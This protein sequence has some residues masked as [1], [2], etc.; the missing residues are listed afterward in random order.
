[1]SFVHTDEQLS[2][3]R[4]SSSDADEIA[5]L[6]LA[7]RV[8]ALP[9]LP[10]VHTDDEVCTWIRDVAL[11]R[12][13][14]WV[15]RRNSAIAGF[16][17]LVEDELEQLYVLPGYYRCGVGRKLLDLAKA[18]SSAR[19]FLYTFQ[20]NL[21]ARAFYESQGFRI[22]HVTNGLRNEEKEPDIC[23]EWIAMLVGPY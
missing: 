23:Y 8:E 1:L 15:A 14:A 16:M 10:R 17:V 21:R 13:E 11:K 20:R 4:A 5:R 7:S 3:E 9:Y 19:L 22:I 18:R 12:G 2:L 6:Y